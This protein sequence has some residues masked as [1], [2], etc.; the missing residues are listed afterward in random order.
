[1]IFG[2]VAMV[3]QVT[4]RDVMTHEVVRVG[5]AT[6]YR[7]IVDLLVERR[8]S[9]VPVVDEANRVVGVVSEA[10]LLHRVEFLGEEHERRVFERPSR[11]EARAK[12]HAAAARDL[13]TSPAVTVTP[14]AP[15]AS[16]AKIMAAAGVKLLPVVDAAGT[17]VGIVARA[18]LL[19]MYVRPDATVRD[20]VVT[21]VVRD[22]LWIDPATVGVEVTDGVVTLTGT[23]DRRS[24]AAILARL[25]SG[26][27]GVIAVVDRLA[28]EFDDA[29]EKAS[30]FYQTHPFSTTTQQ[31]Q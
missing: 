4:V 15:V 9:A 6:P 30:R 8:I 14:E 10:D 28:W 27:P 26:V 29:E 25:T 17:L 11:Q 1:M 16:A 24:T 12:S 23:L 19:T 13:M 21:T 2:E 20:D 31:P 18:D 3:R 5:E 22:G 7:A